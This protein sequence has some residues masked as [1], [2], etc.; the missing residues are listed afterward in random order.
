MLQTNNGFDV[1]KS[2]FGDYKI[3]FVLRTANPGSVET[4]FFKMRQFLN[5]QPVKISILINGTF[6]K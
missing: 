6:I 2:W 5:K 1:H 4:G 3:E